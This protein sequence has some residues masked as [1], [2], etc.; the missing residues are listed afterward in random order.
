MYGIDV[1]FLADKFSEWSSCRSKF[2][3]DNAAKEAGCCR[4]QIVHDWEVASGIA[5]Q[6]MQ[7]AQ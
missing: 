5:V 3:D 7:V 2:E 6:I 4:L 1:F